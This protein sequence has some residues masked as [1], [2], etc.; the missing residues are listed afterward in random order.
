M[1]VDSQQRPARSEFA[2]LMRNVEPRLLQAL[3]S[4]YGPRDGREAP[5]EAL[6]WAWEHWDRLGP[7]DETESESGGEEAKPIV[8]SLEFNRG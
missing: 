7:I 1:A 6:S 8:G 3:V 2:A 4:V 5:A